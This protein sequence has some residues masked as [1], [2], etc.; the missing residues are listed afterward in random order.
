MRPIIMEMSAFGPFA[1]RTTVDFEKLGSR[2][3]YLIT[4]DTGAGKTTIFDALTFALF[5]EASGTVR[6]KSMLRSM[7]ASSDTPTEVKLTFQYGGKRYIVRRN[8]EYERRARRGEGMTTQ[9]AEAELTY[10]DGR[11]ITRVNDVDAA[12]REILGIDRKQFSQIAMIAQGDFRKLLLAE[13]KERQEIFREVFQTKYYQ[14]FQDKLK[15]SA[16]EI[17]R[18]ANDTKKS[19]RQYINGAE[20]SED[21]V[22]IQELRKAKENQLPIADVVDLLESIIKKD[23]SA[24]NQVDQ[25]VAELE[26]QLSEVHAALG[27][28]SELE[29]A[30][31]GLEAAEL[32]EKTAIEACEICKEEYLSASARSAEAEQLGAVV[33][34]IETLLPDYEAREQKQSE[35]AILRTQLSDKE[36]THKSDC[37]DL[38][39]KANELDKFQEEYRGLEKAGEEKERLSREKERVEKRSSELESF[40]KLISDL[41]DLETD[42][43]EKQKDYIAAQKKADASKDEYDQIHRAFLAEQ[44]GILAQELCEGEP[45]PVC[46]SKD[47]PAPAHLSAHA[48]TESALKAAKKKADAERGAAE[49]ASQSAANALGKK[50]TAE[51]EFVTRGN[52]LFEALDRANWAEEAK[53]Q[54]AAQQSKVLLLDDQIIAEQNKIDRKNKLS[55]LIPSKQA[56]KDALEKKIGEQATELAAMKA[57]EEEYVKQIEAFGKRLEFKDKN[58]ATQEKQRLEKEKKQLTDA[59]QRTDKAYRESQTTL[60]A[61]KGKVC[62]LREQLEGVEIPDRSIL[63]KEESDI[64]D[65][66]DAKTEVGKKLSTRISNNQSALDN[67]RKQSDVLDVQEKK[68]KWVK[69]LSN[70]ANGTVQGKEKIMLE[71]FVQMTF[72]DRIVARANTRLMIMTSGQYE[73]K[74]RATAG[75]LR[76]QSGLELDVIDHY[77]STGRSVKTLSGGESFMAALSLAL[78]LSDEIQSSAGGIRLDTMFVDEGF[79][80]LDE[81]ALQQAL[82]ALSDLAESDRLVGIISHVSE[83]K[84]KIDRQIVVK[85]EKSGGSQVFLQC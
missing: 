46:G 18:E 51:K 45:C 61:A 31:Q 43:S 27:R 30:K 9:R 37:E 2:G 33:T 16:S 63:E 44:A 64:K 10:P 12:I 17:D 57:Q 15:T 39:S 65:K 82:R 69:A 54:Y 26:R 34:T 72:F 35:L 76:S 52:A 62:Q 59:I 38:T 83:L 50:E 56:E 68:L 19:I 84:E 11:V 55:E 3:L 24:L 47:H 28:A 42:L 21:D 73:L 40:N 70:T 29:K 80:S 20:C 77:N 22:C 14:L 25:D 85:K 60:S 41:E 7:Y 71:T 8:P 32:A 23:Q 81:N 36:K 48:P 66:K 74:R 6:D 79:G 1:G 75:D 53:R 4:G 67:I 5:G 13:T 78:G 58:T 49:K